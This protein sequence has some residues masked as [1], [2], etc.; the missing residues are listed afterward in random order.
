MELASDTSR[1][2]DRLTDLGETSKNIHNRPAQDC[3]TGR[4]HPPWVSRRT[5]NKRSRRYQLDNRLET[6]VRHSMYLMWKHWQPSHES[7]S[8]ECQ[9]SSPLLRYRQHGPTTICLLHRGRVHSFG[10][11]TR[12]SSGNTSSLTGG[13]NASVLDCSMLHP[14]VKNRTGIRLCSI[15]TLSPGGFHFEI[16]LPVSFL[17]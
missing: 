10:C 2:I 9:S 15:N 6:I 1:A 5:F 7:L 14:Q 16:E 3:C 12:G 17:I 4:A 8:C 13:T 11:Q